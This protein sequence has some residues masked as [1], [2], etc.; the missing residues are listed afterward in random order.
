MGTHQNNRIGL[1]VFVE[2]KVPFV[3]DASIA[4]SQ[5]KKTLSDANRATLEFVAKACEITQRRIAQVYYYR[6]THNHQ[7]A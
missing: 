2:H 5:S 6:Q 1:A 4:L 7:F 3:T